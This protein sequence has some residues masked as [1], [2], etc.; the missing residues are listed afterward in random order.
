MS[1]ASGERS[2]PLVVHVIYAL[3]TG[4]LENGLVNII[5]RAPR[6][7]YRHAIVCLT[8][9][10][11]FE[12]RI[13]EGAAEVYA[14]HKRPGHDL[15]MYLRL[16]RLLRRLRPAVVHTRNLAALETQ[17]LGLLM[18]GTVRIHGEHGRDVSD[19][20][21]SNVTYQRLRRFLSPLVHR[22]ICVS[23]DLAH[24]LEQD[25]GIRIEKIRQIYN[26]VDHQNF[27]SVAADRTLA[28]EGFLVDDAFVVGTVGRLAAVK[29]QATLLCAVEHIL[30][31]RPALK[32]RLPRYSRWRWS[33][34]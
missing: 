9:S 2:P 27:S 13:H 12:S 1:E 30:T 32:A 15:G 14:L 17:I 20:D 28:P 4:G 6:D 25:V 3:G 11:P 23:Q 29:D 31:Q 5:N 18:P 10:G 24:W 21:G 26:G 33:S 22:F 16:Y 19:L 7:R 8:E 34:A